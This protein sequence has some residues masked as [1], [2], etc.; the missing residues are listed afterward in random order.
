M[1][2]L[3]KTNTNKNIIA[4]V[5]LQYGAYL[6]TIKCIESIEKNVRTD[7]QIIVVDNCS[8][9]DS[10]DLLKYQVE[11]KTNVVLVKTETNLG[12]A[13]GNNFGISFA[14]K[15]YDPDFIVVLNND[16]RLLDDNFSDVI[17][18]E[19]DGSK[20]DLLGPMILSGDGKYTS[21]PRR[22]SV[23]SVQDIQKSIKL[24][25]LFLHLNR[26]KLDFIYHAFLRMKAYKRKDKMDCSFFLS[27]ME[28][29]E[30]HGSFLIFSR[31]YFKKF[32]GFDGRTFMYCEEP[33]LFTK[34]FS[35][36]GKTVYNPRIC[37]F[38]AEDASTNNAFPKE[39]GKIKFYLENHIKSC[40]VL[41]RVID[42]EMN[43]KLREE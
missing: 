43:A 42:E 31:E 10:Y 2:L 7:Y 28:N 1:T 34:L 5:I 14:R 38:H 21:S 27:R 20:F 15:N 16:T 4:F 6:E 40:Q 13:N 17:Y 30:L 22:N 23:W 11:Q 36:K 33:I 24:E 26:F 41:L 25:K 29:V 32:D 35:A 9:D 19:F 3:D 39:N 18:E 8:P 12:F 37:I